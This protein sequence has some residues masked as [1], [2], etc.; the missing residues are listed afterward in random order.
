[1]MNFTIKLPS[2]LPLY[3][4]IAVTIFTALRGYSSVYYLVLAIPLFYYLLTR[5]N[6]LFFINKNHIAFYLFIYYSF[7]VIL[8]S[9]AFEL[10][11][12]SIGG[13]PRLLLMPLIAFIF[14][15]FLRTE[16]D[17]LIALNVIFICIL[18]GALSIIYQFFLGPIAWFAESATRGVLTR[19]SSLLGSL[20][21]FGSVT[22]FLLIYIFGPLNSLRN[23]FSRASVFGLLCIA[24]AISLQ[25]IALLILMIS[26]LFLLIYNIK[27]NGLRIKTGNLVA[28]GLLILSLPL[29]LLVSPM[30][31]TY[32]SSLLT[33]VFNFDAG[34]FSSSLVSVNDVRTSTLTLE[35]IIQRLYGFTLL[36]Y[37]DYGNYIFFLGVGMRG[38]AGVMG[39]D[40]IS[41]HNGLLELLLM[42]GPL[43]LLIA[44]FLYFDVQYNLYRDITHKLSATFFILNCIFLVVAIFTAGAFFQPSVSILFWLSVAY[45]MLRKTNT[46]S[47]SK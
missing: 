39:M 28:L 40:G 32:I 17:F 7:F 6:S 4:L 45:T 18:V 11:L 42:G 20:T 41:A 36:A 35:S 21:V 9:F 38:G 3:G 8:W 23:V 43:Y 15:N 5:L 47:L 14:F 44:L 30:M 46:I 31:Q 19:Y 16:K 27:F 25:K 12:S 37:E 10:S 24:T 34:Q 2:H 33:I 1:M 13:I 29:L 26:S 22:G